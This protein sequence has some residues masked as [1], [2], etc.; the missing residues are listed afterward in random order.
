MPLFSRQVVLLQGGTGIKLD[1]DLSGMRELRVL[2]A[3]K[4]SLAL[5]NELIGDGDGTDGQWLETFYQRLGA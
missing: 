1:F 5:I 2:S 3:D 4:Q